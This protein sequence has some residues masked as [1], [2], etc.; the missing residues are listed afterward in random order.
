M[1]RHCVPGILS[2]AA[3]K[4]KSDSKNCSMKEVSNTR[5]QTFLLGAVTES[6]VKLVHTKLERISVCGRENDGPQR[7]LCRPLQTWEYVT[8]HGDRDFAEDLKAMGRL[9]W[10]IWMG[11]SNHINP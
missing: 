3:G 1:E 4:K 7:C 5:L 11:Q 8:F 10:I 9:S 2:R 6:Q